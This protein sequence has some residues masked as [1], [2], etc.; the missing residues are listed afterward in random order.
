MFEQAAIERLLNHARRKGG[1]DADDIAREL[2]IERMTPTEIADVVAHLEAA[3]ISIDVDPGL[4][5]SRPGARTMAPE[6]DA[7]FKLPD[8]PKSMA[9]VAN[10]VGRIE[11]PPIAR[12]DAAPVNHPLYRGGWTVLVIALLLVFALV[13][14]IVLRVS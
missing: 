9:P 14:Y 3:G 4:L 11:A 7:R 10:T 12:A 5:A 1:L 13:A 6:P 2:P 8:E